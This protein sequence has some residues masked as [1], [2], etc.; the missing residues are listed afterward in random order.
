MAIDTRPRVLLADDH[1]LV[2][3]GLRNLLESDGG[4]VVLGEVAAGTELQPFI[5]EHD[6][7]V[8]VLDLQLRDG[9]ALERIQPLVAAF[10]HL[11]ILVLSMHDQ[12]VY[13]ERCLKLGAKGYL[14]KEEAAASIVEAIK[15][16]AAG[17]QYLSR[18]FAA[19]TPG[20]GPPIERLSDRE[21]QVFELTGDGL[22]T[23]VVAERLGLSEKTV[24]AHK[25]N[26]KRKLGIEHGTELARL[27]MS[28]RESGGAAPK[29]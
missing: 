28:W 20:K 12:R 10:P 9:S 26:I 15:A 7:D 4:F 13:A 5:A 18:T 22:P 19:G 11:A 14:M 29:A 1:Q 27:A 23:R 6:P 8:L 16:V 25:A 2:R 3:M 21:L 17:Q 24:E